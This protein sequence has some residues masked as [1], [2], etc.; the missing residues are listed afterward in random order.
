M[1]KRRKAYSS[2][3]EMHVHTVKWRDV[4]HNQKCR[5]HAI[6]APKGHITLVLYIQYLGDALRDIASA[7]WFS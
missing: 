4:W 1:V 5:P 3:S 7:I 2:V 6:K